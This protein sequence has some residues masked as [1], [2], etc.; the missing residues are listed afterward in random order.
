[1]GVAV[2]QVGSA[3]TGSSASSGS[4][5]VNKPTGVQSGDVL[6]VFGASNKGAWDTLPSG[7]T[8]IDVSTDATFTNNYRAYAWYKVC[9][10]SEPSSYSFGSTT[11]AGSGAPMVAT[12]TAWRGVL[13]SSPIMHNARTDAAAGQGEPYTAGAS[14]TQSAAGRVVQARTVRVQTSS[15]VDG[16][17]TFSSAT[18]GWSELADAGAFSGGTVSYGIGHYG[19]TAD[20]SS[21]SQ[22]CP[23]ITCSQT[24]SDN[25][26]FLIALR[27]EMDA[28]TAPTAAVTAYD[29]ASLTV[30]TT[31]TAAAATVTANDATVL[32]GV[33]TAAGSAG[34]SVTAFDAQG[35]IIFPAFAGVSA[36][37]ASVRITTDSGYATA[38]VTVGSAVPYFG[39][40]ESRRWRIAAEDRTWRIP[41]ED[42][43]WRIPSEDN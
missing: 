7:F 19:K 5:T 30:S 39:A 42:R 12:M 35:W 6:I 14:F 23:A 3:T 11:A 22:T 18:G 31:A 24:E 4:F 29:A 2:S 26:S 9:G 32:T 41:A 15:G 27:G 37:D 16:T 28:D 1:M 36:Y 13:N 21:G 34:A 40:P 25:V 20:T 43:T 33:A 17:P 10:G 8:Q 38:S